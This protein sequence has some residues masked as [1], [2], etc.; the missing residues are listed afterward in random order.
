MLDVIHQG[1]TGRHWRGN[2][3]IALSNGCKNWNPFL[4]ICRWLDGISM[5]FPYA[6]DCKADKFVPHLSGLLVLPPGCTWCVD[7]VVR[8][9]DSPIFR[10]KNRGDFSPFFDQMTQ[11][12]DGSKLVKIP[13]CPGCILLTPF[14]FCMEG[15]HIA[16]QRQQWLSRRG[17]P[18]G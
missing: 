16:A 12:N 15:A 8:F 4:L 3:I 6:P 17:S 2:Q 13:F 9:I 10:V 7:P 18:N 1:R 11:K 5:D 14:T